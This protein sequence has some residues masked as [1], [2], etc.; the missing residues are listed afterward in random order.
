LPRSSQLS[1]VAAPSGSPSR[2]QH[3]RL[4]HLVARCVSAFRGSRR[5]G[6]AG[7]RYA[8]HDVWNG[9]SHRLVTIERHG[10]TAGR[11]ADALVSSARI[12]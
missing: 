4:V 1:A 10:P 3:D 2:Q 6:C 11:I 9:A 12:R 7:Q 5:Q 8:G